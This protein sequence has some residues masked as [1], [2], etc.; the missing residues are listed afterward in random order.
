LIFVLFKFSLRMKP[1]VTVHYLNH[2]PPF[3]DRIMGRRVVFSWVANS[4]PKFTFKKNQFADYLCA[5]IAFYCSHTIDILTP[6]VAER[7]R[8]SPYF[9]RISITTGGSFVDVNHFKPSEKKINDIVFLGRTSYMKNAVAFLEAV[10]F[11]FERMKI[12]GINTRFQIFGAPADQEEKVKEL[13]SVYSSLGIPV[14]RGQTPD[15]CSVLR[16]AKVF[17]SLQ[18]ASNYPSK[19]LIEAMSCGCVPIINLSGESIMMAN[20]N[21]AVFIDEH[22]TVQQLADAAC[23]ILLLS[24]MEFMRR[25]KAVREF[26]IANFCFNKQVDYYEKVWFPS[27]IL[28]EKH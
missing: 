17:V 27:S 7:F 14:F 20:E 6:S 13:M 21:D 18:R 24:D 19:S 23:S 5:T 4:F 9:D 15:P 10:P 25:S 3:I 26:A 1:G 8:R 16:S 2:A 11:V 28:S 22:F 12:A